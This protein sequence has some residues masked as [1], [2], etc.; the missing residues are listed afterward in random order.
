[1]NKTRTLLGRVTIFGAEIDAH[2]LFILC[3]LSTLLRIHDFTKIFFRKLRRN[4]RVGFEKHKFNH[5]L[6]DMKLM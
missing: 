3:S 6:C 1:M 4:F 2:Y 5:I